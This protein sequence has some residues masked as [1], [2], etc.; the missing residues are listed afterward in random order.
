MTE[1]K[2]KTGRFSR[3]MDFVLAKSKDSKVEV[4]IEGL[5]EHSVKL[6]QDKRLLER[7]EEYITL[8]K[9]LNE[10]IKYTTLNE[11]I[12]ELSDMVKMT[13]LTVCDVAGI[14]ARSGDDQRFA[15]MLWGWDGLYSLHL[16]DCLRV[17]FYWGNDNPMNDKKDHMYLQ[18]VVHL[19]L[20][21]INHYFCKAFNVLNYCFRDVDVRA[22]S[23]TVIQ[24]MQPAYGQNVDVNRAAEG[25]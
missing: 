16:G 7:K 3:F 22:Q 17:K 20:A 24:N 8:M 14:Y 12:D 15:R 23:V 21:L 2:P 10:P 1:T 18:Q 5:P 13:H 11:Y 25:Q 4:K 9:L 6:I 19:H